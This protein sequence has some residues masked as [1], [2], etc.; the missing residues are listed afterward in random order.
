MSWRF[1]CVV[2]TFLV[3]AAD[4]D[5]AARYPNGALLLEAEELARPETLTECCILDTRSKAEF[6]AGHIPQAIHVDTKL[7]NKKFT[8]YVAALRPAELE[9]QEAA[10]TGGKEEKAMI[11]VFTEAGL[12]LGQ[13]NKLVVYGNDLRDTARIWWI[14]RYWGQPDVR[15]LNGGWKAWQAAKNKEADYGK[16]QLISTQRAA[17]P[18][19]HKRLALKSQVLEALAKQ[20]FQIVDARSTKEFCGDDTTAKRNGSIP[21]ARHLEWSD[22]IDKKTQRF[23]T[24]AELSRLFQEARIDPK[25]PAVTYCQSGGRA[26]VMAFA[27]EL[28]GAKQV[29]NYYR[30][31]AEWGNDEKTPVARP[32]PRR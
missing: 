5:W 2:L 13:E 9:G 21:T 10:L 14:L 17:L 19:Q 23:K 6:E 32:R 18:L 31:W 30:S 16:R 28:M 20:S 8:A 25:K 29:R 26:A 27:L 24:A 15:I 7:W 22:L 3:V 12:Y 1:A 11:K 4:K